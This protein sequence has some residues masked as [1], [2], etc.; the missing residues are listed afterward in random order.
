MD[1][2]KKKNSTQR[3]IMLISTV[4]AVLLIVAGIFIV[5]SLISDDGNK[6][7]RA[8]QMVTL[9]KPPPPP[10]IEEKPPEPEIKKEEILEPEPEETHEEMADS[11]SDQEAGSDLG[12]DADG[13]AGSDGFG[14][15]AKKGG[16]AL[17]GGDSGNSSL[18]KRY[19]WYTQMLQDRIQERLQKELERTGGIPEGDHQATVRI[20]MDDDGNIIT[21]QIVGSSGNHKMDT[22]INSAVKTATIDEPPPYEMPK[23]IKLKISSKG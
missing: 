15:V 10:E 9:M 4:V 7:K 11:E 2:G 8:V 18:L 20:V 17:I 1:S 5:K 22:A 19:A 6:R 23:A 12:I 13:V 3:T 16:K 14:L 21:C